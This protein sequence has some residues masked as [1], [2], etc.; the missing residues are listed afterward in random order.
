MRFARWVFA[1]AGV[2]GLLILAPMLAMEAQIGRDHPPPI[3]HPEYF[4]GFVGVAVA[5]QVAF[6]IIATDP[7][8]YRWIIIPA[9]LEKASFGIA[10][11]LLACTRGVP[12][13]I[14][15]GACT[16]GLLGTLFVLSWFST[17]ASTRRSP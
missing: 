14:V 4:Y 11:L 5:W 12:L 7:V 1:I 16:D 10:I 17:K 15:A 3:T 9:I 8:R 2:Y 6:L 13:P